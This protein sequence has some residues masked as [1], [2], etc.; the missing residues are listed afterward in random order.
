MYPYVTSKEVVWS[1]HE[2]WCVKNALFAF[3]CFIINSYTNINSAIFLH[4]AF[5]LT[6]ANQGRILSFFKK[7]KST[8]MTW[9]TNARTANRILWLLLPSTIQFN[10]SHSF[11]IRFSL[12][13]WEVEIS[14][15]EHYGNWAIL[16]LITKFM[17][18]FCCGCRYITT[19]VFCKPPISYLCQP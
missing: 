2:S 10:T 19:F 12:I 11:C 15:T 5:I 18:T 4:L 14:G 13:I 9:K 7:A 16:M 6:C 3:A 1:G 8:S 17:W